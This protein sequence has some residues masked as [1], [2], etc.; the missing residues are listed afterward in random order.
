MTRRWNSERLGALGPAPLVACVLLAGCVSS[1]EPSGT[2]R[3]VV[4]RSS[5]S[6]LIRNPDGSVIR[7]AL[8]RLRL[9]AL[10]TLRTDGFRLPL[11]SPAGDRIAWQARS[12][13]DW[14]M[15][16][17]EPGSGALNAFVAARPLAAES[18]WEVG[19]RLLLGRQADDRGVL[20]ES[21]REDGSRWIGR[22][23][24]DGSEPTWMVQDAR[25]N[26]FGTLGPRGEMGWCHR[27]LEEACLGLS[28]QR[29]EGRLDFPRRDGESWTMPVVATDGIY[30]CSLRDGILDLAF[31]PI[32]PGEH[33]TPSQAEP[34]M[35]RQRLS[36]RATPRTAWQVLEGVCADRAAGPGGLTFYHPQLRRMAIWNPRADRVT[37]LAEGSMAAWMDGE[38]TAICSLSDQLVMQ[39]VPPEP[40]MAPLKL[41]PGLWTCRGRDGTG[42]ILAGPSAD[43]LVVSRLL[44]GDPPE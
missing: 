27:S 31:L 14:P 12:N 17:A 33:L 20:V 36:I 25:M 13:A 24:W 44:L 1:T 26:A 32:R 9:E 29:P 41:I 39:E 35:L 8:L 2:P 10:G 42:F 43:G 38:G 40:G 3:V 37:L 23:P 7:D 28:V 11:V 15:L 5:G 22:L 6:V 4:G 21:I 34:A 19:D 16:L 18:G 30:A